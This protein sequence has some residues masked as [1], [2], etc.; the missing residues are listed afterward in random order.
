[1][2]KSNQKNM[3][4]A[5][6]GLADEDATQSEASRISQVFLFINKLFGCVSRLNG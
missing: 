6:L 5:T 4:S 1:M 2:Q 3:I